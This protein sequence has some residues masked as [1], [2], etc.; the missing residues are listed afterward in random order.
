M[1]ETERLARRSSRLARAAFI[2]SLGAVLAASL[3][4]YF[5]WEN[6]Q[7]ITL[8][9]VPAET[10]APAPIVADNP[11]DL[12][13]DL[14]LQEL[15]RRAPTLR[16]GNLQGWW[17]GEQARKVLRLEAEAKRQL[18]AGDRDGATRSLARASAIRADIPTLANSEKPV[19]H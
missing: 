6:R 14:S 18:L 5:S 9:V 10:V 2:L 8:P 4:F 7:P 15:I 17:A 11:A 16:S 1:D 3:Q 13:A 19:P 12:R